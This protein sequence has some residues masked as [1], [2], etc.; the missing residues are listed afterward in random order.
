MVFVFAKVVAQPE[1]R[2]RVVDALIEDGEGSLR[3]EP[4]TLRF[5]VLEDG[6]DPSV[7]YFYEAYRDQAAFDAHKQGPHFKKA[8]AFLLESAE[9][10]QI[11]SPAMQVLA[12]GGGI[13]IPTGA[14]A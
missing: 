2:S 12:R 7:I 9:K 14:T 1:F 11:S 4:G 10:G 3:D 5:D 6:S 13:F 8:V